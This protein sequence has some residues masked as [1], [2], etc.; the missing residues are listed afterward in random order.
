MK[1]VRIQRHRTKGFNLQATSRAMNGLPCVSVCRPGRWGNP[2]DV[3]LFG[4][5]RS[6]KLFRSTMRGVWN[7]SLVK[8]LSDELADLAYTSHHAFL[9]RLGRHPMEVIGE[10]RGKN[11]ACYCELS[12]EG[13]P[14]QCHAEILLELANAHLPG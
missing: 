3:R 6:M 9:K 11:L 12:R 5:E 2:Y 8:D 14:D 7:P 10:L 13:D 4:R 1:P